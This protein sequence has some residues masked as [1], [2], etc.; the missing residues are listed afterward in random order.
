MVI[1]YTVFALSLGV[2]LLFLAVRKLHHQELERQLEQAEWKARY[3]QQETEIALS[4]SRNISNTIA[5]RLQAVYGRDYAD[6]LIARQMNLNA[7]E[8][9]PREQMQIT[10]N[11]NSAPAA[12]DLYADEHRADERWARERERER[13]RERE[14]SANVR[15][16]AAYTP[17]HQ[18][19]PQPQAPYTS[20]PIHHAPYAD[21]YDDWQDEPRR[22][23]LPQWADDDVLDVD[24]YPPVYPPALIAPPPTGRQRKYA[25]N[26]ERQRAY[27]ERKRRQ[28]FN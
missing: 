7:A 17:P 1:A 8:P 21:D 2:L 14:Y 20:S 25:S 24:V 22:P 10:I 9:Q 5:A 27:R 6:Y 16:S 12:I 23:F 18:W 11:R 15:H 4:V 13:A 28:S 26:A 19:Q 3:Y